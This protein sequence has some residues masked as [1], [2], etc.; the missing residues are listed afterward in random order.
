MSKNAQKEKK[1][2][3]ITVKPPVNSQLPCL[4]VKGIPLKNEMFCRKWRKIHAP[5]KVLD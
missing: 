4:I 5:K 1:I 2:V 3:Q